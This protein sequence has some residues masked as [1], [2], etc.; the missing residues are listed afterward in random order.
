MALITCRDC[1][2]Q[3][4]D[5]AAACPHCGNPAP[6]RKKKT[7]RAAWAGLAVVLLLVV[8]GIG[9]AIQGEGDSGAALAASTYP[10]A[11]SFLD[12][13]PEYGELRSASAVPDWAQGRRVEIGTSTGRLL[14]YLLDGEVVTVY[15]LT[16][17]G[18]R[19]EVYQTYQGP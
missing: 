19:E 17:G 13:H 6:P 12:A 9:Q 14:L 4:S 15:R 3:L 2:K 5:A 7:S 11:V 18:G 8:V 16:D 1:G 10:E